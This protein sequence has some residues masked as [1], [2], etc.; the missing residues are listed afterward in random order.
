M[1]AYFTRRRLPVLAGFAAAT[2]MVAACSSGSTSQQNSSGGSTPSGSAVAASS[3]KCGVNVVVPP[4]SDPDGVWKGLPAD[5]QARYSNWPYPLY[6]SPW[7]SFA[8]KKG[9]WK[10]GF[11]SFPI[12][13]NW[14]TDIITQLKTEIA[15]AK[16][17][18]LSTG[19]LETYVQPS[20]ATATPEQQISAI[21]NMVRDGVDGI[22]LLPGST[23]PLAPAIDAAGKAGVPVVLL[24][25]VVPTSKYAINVWSENQSATYAGTMALIHGK[26]NVV[27]LRGVQGAP[28]EAPFYNDGLAAVQRC[29]D[30]KLI[31][32]IP[33][34][35][36]DAGAKTSMLK[37]LAS[38]PTAKVDAVIQNGATVAGLIE[39]FQ[40]VGKPVPIISGGEINGGALWWW[41]QHKDTYQTVGTYFNG[42]QTAHTEW[43]IMIRVLAGKGLKMSGINIQPE[44]ITNSNLA[45]YTPPHA[46]NLGD[47]Y[48]LPQLPL[49]GWGGTS[50]YLDPYFNQPGNPGSLDQ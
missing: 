47:Q 37:F 36:T 8:G 16:A 39:A 23:T 6:K 2:A 15:A 32:T 30:A 4:A 42:Y 3:S 5:I 18:G 17:K 26:G 45:Q 10:F 1:S 24:D 22:F 44:T 35:W 49:A 34:D 21:Q 11:I 14:Q 40:Q 46:I 20:F 12:I 38:H 50:A 48:D 43:Q 28:S 13:S 25:N 33:G 27:I 9:P 31:G 7:A 19:T 41:S 29:P